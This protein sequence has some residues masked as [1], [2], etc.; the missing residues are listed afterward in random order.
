M[1][2]NTG[3]RS[4]GE[5]LITR[6]TSDVAV[7]CSS[8]SDSSRVRCCSASNN[9]TFPDR[10]HRLISERLQQRNLALRELSSVGSCNR[11][12]SNWVA[13]KQQRHCHDA[14]IGYRLGEIQGTVGGIRLYVRD[15]GDSA[16]QYRTADSRVLARWPRKY[17]P[18]DFQPFNAQTMTASKVQDIAVKPH[19][20]GE[21]A[22]AQPHRSLGNCVEHR[23]DVGRRARNDAQHLGGR[24]LLLQR[25]GKVP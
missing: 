8:A 12:R 25:L 19:H 20:E 15:L 21:L 7:C 9:R 16:V 1:A 5:L 4:P 14:S 3:S 22:T 13:I 18:K 24:G 11:D 17:P 6:S 2:W 23:L 10:N